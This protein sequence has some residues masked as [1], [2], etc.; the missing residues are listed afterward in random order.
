MRFGTKC[1]SCD[2]VA[3]ARIWGGLHFRFST[4]DGAQLGRNVATYVTR[5]HFRPEAG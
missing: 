3:N 4:L 2:E 5:A 1:R